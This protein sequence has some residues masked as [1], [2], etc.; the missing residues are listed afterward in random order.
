M[1]GK[2]ENS[3]SVVIALP[4]SSSLMPAH[5]V[6]QTIALCSLAKART[7]PALISS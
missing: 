7:L 3:P 1:V 2:L 6:A 5:L 4:T